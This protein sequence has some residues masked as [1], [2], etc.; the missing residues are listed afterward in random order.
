MAPESA[1]PDVAAIQD[2][3]CRER[4]WRDREDWDAMR[5]AYTDDARVR[6]TWFEGTID[7]Y[8]EDSR[9]PAWD[10]S[11]LSRHRLSP[12]LVSVHG[13]R[14]LA[15]TP[16]LVELRLEVDSV[17]VDVVISV[18][19]LSRVARTPQ[20]WK[21]ASMDAIYEKDEMRP[22]YP[23]QRLTI[24]ASDT[25]PYRRSYQ[26]LAY[27]ARGHLPADIPG[28]DRPELVAA[29]YDAAGKWLRAEG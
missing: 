5:A 16:A 23:A 24:S 18:R 12:V 26:F 4:H 13:D 27:G 1:W 22:V 15:E 2:L 20:G 28:D 8:I 19:L 14:A 17:L 3:A 7:D 9:N 29:L 11:S 10:T 25:A 6:V 21:L